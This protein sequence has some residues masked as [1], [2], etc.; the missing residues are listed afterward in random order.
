MPALGSPASASPLTPPLVETRAAHGQEAAER[1]QLMAEHV[2]RSDSEDEIPGRPDSWVPKDDQAN[3]DRT[4]DVGMPERAAPPA[5]DDEVW[6]VVGTLPDVGN[7][8]S[9]VEQSQLEHRMRTMEV[10]LGLPK[11]SIQRQGT[12]AVVRVKSKSGR[13]PKAPPAPPVA[14]S[15]SEVRFGTVDDEEMDAATAITKLEMQQGFQ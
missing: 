14:T 4:V 9:E 8:P 13:V 6:K 15:S 7:F 2:D 5:S 12:S 3:R 11:D 10:S 1:A